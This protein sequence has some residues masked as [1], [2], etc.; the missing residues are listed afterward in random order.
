MKDLPN[1]IKIPDFTQKLSQQFDGLSS[2]SKILQSY[3]WSNQMSSLTMT[4]AM[5]KGIALQQPNFAN[6]TY[7]ISRALSNQAKFAIPLTAIDSIKS[8]GMQN[9]KLFEGLNNALNISQKIYNSSHILNLQ[10]AMTGISAQLAELASSQNKWNLLDDFE[11]IT[12]EAV[13]IN[14]RIIE[15]EGLSKENFE[16]L[17]QFL[18]RIEIKIDKSEKGTSAI[19]WKLLTLL[20]FILAIS[21]EISN[22]KPKPEYATKEQV[23]DVITKHFNS[24]DEKLKQQKEYR[25]TNREC[26]VYLKPKTKTVIL[27]KLEKNFELVILNINHKWI[28]VSYLNPNDGLPQTGWI[29]KKYT[30]KTK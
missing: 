7:G 5:L 3:D 25:I 14:E 13:S 11:E 20:S 26:N 18:N 6:S 22:W 21:A 28:Y 24:F 27:A 17:N 9:Q 8:I 12:N 30:E 4:Q 23:E 2:I 19:F 10:N 29:M 15:D 1:S 16:I